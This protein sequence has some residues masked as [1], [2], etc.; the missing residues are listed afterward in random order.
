[1]LTTRFVNL[2]HCRSQIALYS[3]ERAAFHVEERSH[4]E[5]LE[6][7]L[8]DATALSRVGHPFRCTHFPRR[9]RRTETLASTHPARHSIPINYEQLADFVQNRMRMPHVYQ[10]V[11]LIAPRREGKWE[12]VA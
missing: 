8:L 5:A 1:M 10:P 6:P 7:D 9:V 11:M 4:I 2:R 3:E 12:G